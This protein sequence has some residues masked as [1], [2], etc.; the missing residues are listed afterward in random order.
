M[1]LNLGLHGSII[2][3]QNY[4]ATFCIENDIGLVAVQFKCSAHNVFSEVSTVEFRRKGPC[5]SSHRVEV[6]SSRANRE[7]FHAFLK[8]LGPDSTRIFFILEYY[9]KVAKY[10]ESAIK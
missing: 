2:D 9:Q 6:G 8:S 7:C 10:S 4:D 5:L 1:G 3:V